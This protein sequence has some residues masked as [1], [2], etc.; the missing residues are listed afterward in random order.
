MSFPKTD[1][2]QLDLFTKALLTPDPAPDWA[3]QDP[4]ARPAPAPPLPPFK[5]PPAPPRINRP[6]PP[7]TPDDPPLRR[8]VLGHY[9]VD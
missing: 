8:I 5:A 9:A 6:S 1:G 3:A 7:R 4:A 2:P